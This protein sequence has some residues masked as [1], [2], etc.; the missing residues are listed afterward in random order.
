MTGA[1][2]REPTGSSIR[3]PLWER[4][5]IERIGVRCPACRSAMPIVLLW[6]IGETCPRCSRPVESAS[7]RPRPHG[8]L[9]KAL[10]VSH[11]T[12]YGQAGRGGTPER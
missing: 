5:M 3:R 8:V 11:A 10:E 1:S 7:R 12:A 6:A 2:G 4:L 9:G